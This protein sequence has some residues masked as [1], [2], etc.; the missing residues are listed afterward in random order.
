MVNDYARARAILDARIDR[1][2]DRLSKLRA[3]AALK[4]QTH[5]FALVMLGTVAAAI[6]LSVRQVRNTWHAS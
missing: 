1:L 3:I 2:L 6:G 4:D 5:H